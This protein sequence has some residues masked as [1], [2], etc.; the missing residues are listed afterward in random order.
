MCSRVID[1]NIYITNTR[2]F[3]SDSK[4]SRFLRCLQISSDE[5][6]LLTNKKFLKSCLR[7]NQQFSQLNLCYLH[8]DLETDMLFRAK[9]LC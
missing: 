8:Q 3:N 4:L 6:A 1:K 7:Y 9:T 2:V 5:I